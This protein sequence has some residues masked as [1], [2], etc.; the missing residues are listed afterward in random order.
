MAR[1]SKRAEKTQ[2]SPIRKLKPVADQAR[3][4]GK[5]VYNLNIGQPDIPTPKSFLDGVKNLPKVLAYSPSP[6]LDEAVDALVSYY[7]DQ[8]IPLDRGQVI[9]TAGGSEAIT[10][11][12]MAVT[13]PGDEIIV[14]EPFYTNY[15]SYATM[16][17]VEIRPIETRS[18]TGF[19]LPDRRA[20]EAAITPKTKA[21]LFCN[22][23]NP[24]GTVYTRDE[25]QMLR[26]VAVKHDLFLISDEVYRE[27]V[28]DG[29]LHTSVLHLDGLEERAIL[30]DSISKRF[31]ACGARIGA[32]A[33]RN[34]SIMQAALKFAQARLSPPTLGQLGLIHF[35][36]SST[37]RREVAE[38]IE[39][40]EQRRDVVYEEITVIPGVVCRKPQ[41]AFYII[42]QFPINDAEDFCSWLL[43][44]FELQGETVLMAPAADFYKTPGKGRDEVRLA[45]VLNA[46]ALKRAI[47]IVQ[48]GLDAY[49][50]SHIGVRARA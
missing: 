49:S 50:H 26:D 13:D 35:L 20:I 30:V 15:N 29:L 33:S 25:L 18:E 41:G 2:F 4:A 39:E 43:T 6:G 8:N 38:M 12:L 37:Y 16:A 40:F 45:Y 23:G 14:P 10:F 11:A 3:A 19:R 27:F 5:R 24:T 44:E 48:A 22:P 47:E 36:K 34:P 21:I 46:Q 31:S 1:V 32:I 7:E 28:Y 42:A 17:G 9:I